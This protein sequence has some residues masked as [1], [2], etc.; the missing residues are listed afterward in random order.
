MFQFAEPPPDLKKLKKLP[1]PAND[2]KTL[3]QIEMEEKEKEEG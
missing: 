2:H 1:F 3:Q